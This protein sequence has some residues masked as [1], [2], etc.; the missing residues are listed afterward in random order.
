MTIKGDEYLLK[1][2]F[3]NILDN[4]CKYSHDNPVNITVG[5]TGK[6][7]E[8]S[9]TDSGV[10]I[11]EAEIGKVSEPFYRGTN[12]RTMKGIGIGLSLVNQIITNHNGSMKLT[13]KAGKGTT[14]TIL[15][16]SVK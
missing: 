5:H 16:P 3:S 4:A 8:I 13:S 2:A 12:A 14:V 1:I 9:F 6:Y 10:G 11:P 15:L 7:L